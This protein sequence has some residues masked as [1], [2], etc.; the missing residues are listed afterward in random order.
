[1][2]TVNYAR[3][4]G[5]LTGILKSLEMRMRLNKI[6]LSDSDF[7]KLA[8]LIAKDIASAEEDSTEQQ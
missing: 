4:S 5:S 7:A 1:M 2:K 8:E 3:L 6:Y